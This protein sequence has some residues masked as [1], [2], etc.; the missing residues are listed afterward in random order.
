[1]FGDELAECGDSWFIKP[2][3]YVLPRDERSPGERGFGI[4]S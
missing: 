4:F 2:H 1:M 3:G